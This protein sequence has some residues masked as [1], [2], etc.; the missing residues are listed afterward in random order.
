M[1]SKPIKIDCSHIQLELI[2]FSIIIISTSIMQYIIPTTKLADSNAKAIFITKNHDKF[3]EE[4]IELVVPKLLSTMGVGSHYTLANLTSRVL[5]HVDTDVLVIVCACSLNAE[6]AK[7][8]FAKFKHVIF[9]EL[10]K[11]Y[12]HNWNDLSN[13]PQF[14][15]VNLCCNLKLTGEELQLDDEAKVEAIC[16]YNSALIS[17]LAS[18]ALVNQRCMGCLVNDQSAY[19]IV[20]LAR[21]IRLQ[22]NDAVTGINMEF[23]KAHIINSSVYSHAC[24]DGLS[25]RA[26]MRYKSEVMN[27]VFKNLGLLELVVEEV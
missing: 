27:A 10:T 5:K 9:I 24:S 14:S 1:K 19:D 8:S 16:K 2:P 22:G 25:E 6:K 23:V 18:S 11:V 20:R 7:L 17:T 13:P 3:E 4:V 15:H 12:K 21:D 26:V